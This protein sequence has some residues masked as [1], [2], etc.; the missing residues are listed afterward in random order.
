MVPDL[1]PPARGPEAIASVK[2][3]M[4]YC[5][6]CHRVTPGEPLFCNSCGRSYDAKLCP[7]RHVNPRPAE[8]CSQCGSRDLSTPQP[9]PPLWLAPLL[10]LLTITPG[11]L[12]L[13][14]S[15]ALLMAFVQALVSSQQLLFEFMVLA[16][17]LGVLWWGY[18]Q[19]PGFVRRAFGRGLRSLRRDRLDRSG[20]R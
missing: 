11:I 20:H 12:L 16:L 8:V 9:R 10:W 19:L 13:F 17:L 15:F 1:A 6:N 14:L 2:T 5:Y 7:H 3:S 18:M 4:R